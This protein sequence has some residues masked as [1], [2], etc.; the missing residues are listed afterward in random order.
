MKLLTNSL[1]IVSTPIGNLD[2]ITLRALEVLKNSDFILCEDTRRSIKLLNHFNIKKKLISYHKF[3]EKKQITG[4]LKHIKQGKI[5]SLISDAGTPML[6]DPGRVLINECLENKI[7]IIP[8]PGISSITAAMSVSGFNDK[9]LFYGFLPKTENQLEK[10][11]IETAK[12]DCSLVFFIPSK[13]INFY[14]KKFKDNFQ[15]R[16][17]LIAREI[18][19]IHET[20]YRDYVK[21]IQNFIIPIKG[22]LTVVISEPV[23]KRTSFD[24]QKIINKAKK[25]LKK[26]S[27]KDT[28]DL[29][30][31][32]ENINKKK[33]YEL[34]L[35]IK[36]QK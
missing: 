33:I 25:F 8:I 36:K 19:K 7:E 13:K 2:D 4:V 10:V 27:L 31:K 18:S 26:Y 5:L 1:Y 16:K 11:L 35:K 3:N 12:Y 14:I 34:C 29:I 6:S 17:I 9:F 24:E 21:K 15:N 30:I 23:D 28:V 20:F 22:E 32:T